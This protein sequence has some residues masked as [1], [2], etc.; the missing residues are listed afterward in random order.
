[1]YTECVVIGMQSHW[2]DLC[3][4]I[5]SLRGR[6]KIMRMFINPM[7][8]DLAGGHYGVVTCSANV[9]RMKL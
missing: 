6:N 8:M 2:S 9:V 1:M 3:G 4:C 7:K 5:R